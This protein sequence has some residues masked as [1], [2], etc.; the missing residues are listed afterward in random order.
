MRG[1]FT[2]VAG[3]AMGTV[4][5]MAPITSASAA[6]TYSP[7]AMLQL[8]PEV[9]DQYGI[10][11]TRGEASGLTTQ[12]RS[13]LAA[14]SP[15]LALVPQSRT[16]ATTCSDA[17]CARKIGASLGAR[18]VVFGTVDR[19]GG[20]KWNVLMTA[21]D[22]HT[23]RILDTISYGALGNPVIDGDYYTLLNSVRE[24][25]VCL[26]RSLTGQKPCPAR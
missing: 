25:G 18:A 9:P 2:I 3:L 21:V 12:I 20:V 19:W 5:A 11:P 6:S 16:P 24:A 23:G 1:I 4:F 14:S 8:V 15:G 26:G 7:V 17:D 13:G 22:V 10:A